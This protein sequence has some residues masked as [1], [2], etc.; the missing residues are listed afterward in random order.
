M[1]KRLLSVCLVL[2]GAIV[3]GALPLS[4]QPPKNWDREFLA[5]PS[6]THTLS[7]VGDSSPRGAHSIA[8]MCESVDGAVTIY[9]EI[10]AGKHIVNGIED[11]SVLDTSLLRE[12]NGV[13]FVTSGASN[14]WWLF[15]LPGFFLAPAPEQ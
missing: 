5:D 4:A 6:T 11:T 8:S 13:D 2:F 14:A 9:D 12:G 10:Y 7:Y 15:V 3:F 1:I